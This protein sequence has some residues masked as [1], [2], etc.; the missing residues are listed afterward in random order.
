VWR[1]LI[2]E[3]PLRVF[4]VRRFIAAFLLCELSRPRIAN[5]LQ[6]K[7]P[8]DGPRTAVPGNGCFEIRRAFLRMIEKREK[9]PAL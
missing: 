7:P 9:I 3:R 8:S 6:R 1:L 4:G 5:H 2:L